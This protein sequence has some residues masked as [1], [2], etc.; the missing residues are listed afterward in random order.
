MKNGAS[1]DDYYSPTT[2]AKKAR[3]KRSLRR[4][5]KRGNKKAESAVTSAQDKKGAINPVED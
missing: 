3:G 4:K 5:G 1:A 2:E